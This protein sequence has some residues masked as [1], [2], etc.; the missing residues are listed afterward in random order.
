MSKKFLRSLTMGVVS[1]IVVSLFCFSSIATGQQK[2]TIV[3][4]SMK[5]YGV[6]TVPFLIRKFEQTHPAIQVKF[7][8]MPGP[9]YS[10]E[11]HQYLIT[12]LAAKAGDIDVFTIDC[13]WFP[14]FGEAGWLLP[15]DEYFSETEKAEYF[16]GAVETVSYKGQLVGIPWYLD[17][18]M[19]YYRKDL[20]G[21]YG[22]K[23][24]ETW[25]ELIDQTQII[26]KNENGSKL[27]GFIWQARQAEVLVC[28]LVSFLGSDGAVLDKDGNVVIDNKYGLRTAQL[29]Y[30]LIHKYKITPPEVNTYDE[31]PSRRVF[32]SGDALF[33]RNWSYVW[34]IAQDPQESKV[35]GKIGVVPIPHFEGSG[36]ASCLGGYQ[37]GINKHSRFPDQAVEF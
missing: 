15:L 19:L 29:M 9:N 10:T 35:V 17:A 1:A 18:G 31:E 33:L 2:V 21:K 34:N 6:D 11:I 22:F 4:A 25:N 8:E 23:P 28:D 14:E 37:Y 30:D 32:T 5:T 27:Q 3:F 13:I 16:R 7:V 24:P 12:T 36:S 20:L 26:V